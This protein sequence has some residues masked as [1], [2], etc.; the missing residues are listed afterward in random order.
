MCKQCDQLK[1]GDKLNECML[2]IY[3]RAAKALQVDA[4]GSERENVELAAANLTKMYE[5]D[6]PSCLIRKAHAVHQ[7]RLRKLRRSVQSVQRRR[8]FVLIEADKL[9]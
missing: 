1:D 5:L 7:R 9:D 2:D 4:A 3:A 8:N 6:V